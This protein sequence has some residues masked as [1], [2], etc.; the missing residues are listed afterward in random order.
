MA[1]FPNGHI[2]IAPIESLFV[3]NTIVIKAIYDEP[4]RADIT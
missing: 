3:T 2:S 4:G 1:A